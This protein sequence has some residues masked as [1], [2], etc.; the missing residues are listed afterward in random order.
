MDVGLGRVV[1]VVSE[2]DVSWVFKWSYGCG[3]VVYVVWMRER[4]CFA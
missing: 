1:G 3:R 2:W 4:F